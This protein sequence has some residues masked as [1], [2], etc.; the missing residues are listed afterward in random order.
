MLR[1]TCSLIAMDMNTRLL[2]SIE[3]LGDN[4]TMSVVIQEE[5]NRDEC[6]AFPIEVT[7]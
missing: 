4:S 1:I 3:L 7:S 5:E 6:I 2:R